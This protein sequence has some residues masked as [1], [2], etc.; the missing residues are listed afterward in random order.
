[1]L[2]RVGP[3]YTDAFI[4]TKFK[5][6]SQD[7]FQLKGLVVLVERISLFR[8]LLTLSYYYFFCYFQNKNIVTRRKARQ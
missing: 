5:K 1:M 3:H 2:A 8:F 7:V 4:K 6:A